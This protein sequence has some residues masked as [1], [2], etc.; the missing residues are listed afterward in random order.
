MGCPT[1]IC[2]GLKV[3]QRRRRW[4]YTGLLLIGAAL[5]VSSSIQLRMVT[6][7]RN[8]DVRKSRNFDALWMTANQHSLRMKYERVTIKVASEILVMSN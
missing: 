4:F 5:M 6:W 7:E 2:L 8:S 1:I 3:T